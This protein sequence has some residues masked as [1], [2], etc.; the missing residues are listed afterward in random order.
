MLNRELLA[1]VILQKLIERCH[2]CFIFLQG[3]IIKDTEDTTNDA[4]IDLDDNT[5]LKAFEIE[6]SSLFSMFVRV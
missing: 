6:V 3:Y 1:E 5:F 2:Y 4:Q